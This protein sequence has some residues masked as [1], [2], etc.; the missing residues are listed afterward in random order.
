MELT[1]GIDANRVKQAIVKSIVGVCADLGITSIAEGIETRR[2]L[3]TLRDFGINLFQG[4][5]F[6]KPSFESLASVS[7]EFVAAPNFY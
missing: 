6:A 4:Y 3:D 1:R 7:A 2:E 5:F